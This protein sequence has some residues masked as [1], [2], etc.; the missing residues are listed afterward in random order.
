MAWFKRDFLLPLLLNILASVVLAA[1]WVAVMGVRDTVRSCTDPVFSKV[2]LG[3]EQL[4]RGDLNGAEGYARDAMADG[5][6]PECAAVFAAQIQHARMEEARRKGAIEEAGLAR[7]E[8]YRLAMKAET[9]AGPSPRAIALRDS[10]GAQVLAEAIPIQ[11]A[12]RREKNRNRVQ[13][14]GPVKQPKAVPTDAALREVA[15]KLEKQGGSG[16]EGE[17]K[18]V[19]AVRT[20]SWGFHQAGRGGSEKGGS[21]V[22]KA[23]RH[24]VSPDLPRN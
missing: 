14:L 23:G 1:G 20:D 12:A 3:E 8:C 15:D 18:P 4:M 22:V 13:K 10:C 16:V 24:V 7:S 17:N 6:T 11:P 21:R 9:I 2:K 5:A 19:P